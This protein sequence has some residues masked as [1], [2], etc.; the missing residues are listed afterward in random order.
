MIGAFGWRMQAQLVAAGLATNDGFTGIYE[1]R[2]WRR[3]PK[4][5]PRFAALL[6]DANDLLVVHP[7]GRG[8]WRRAGTGAP[9]RVPVCASL[10]Q[11]LPTAG[12]LMG[13]D[14]SKR[15]KQSAKPAELRRPATSTATSN[16][17]TLTD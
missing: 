13:P 16:R 12:Q 3:Y 5:F 9:P 15:P 2:H 14:M 7:G 11:S 6:P 8:D 10:A 4:Y 1:F 17:L